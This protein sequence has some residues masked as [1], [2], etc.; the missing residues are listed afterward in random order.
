MPDDDR[1][2][3]HV[4]RAPA[5]SQPPSWPPSLD[6]AATLGGLDRAS[7]NLSRLSGLL[8]KTEGRPAAG[9]PHPSD[10]RLDARMEQAE[11]E[12]REYLERSKRR[13]DSLLET[14][15]GAVERQA[16]EMRRDAEE[17]IRARWAQVEVDAN[18]QIDEARQMGDRLVAKRQEQITSLSDGISSRAEALTAGMDD[19]ARVREQFDT[20]IRALSVA[21]DRIAQHQPAASRGEL[22]DLRRPQPNAV[23]A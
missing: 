18:R 19:A 17:S 22:H 23:A 11:R 7:T 15:I 12:A 16:V 3:P 20:F 9:Q 5:A 4:K 6:V 1:V 2:N 8:G 10:P 21:A 13:V 14:M